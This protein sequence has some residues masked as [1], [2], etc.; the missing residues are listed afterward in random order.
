MSKQKKCEQ[1]GMVARKDGTPAM[2]H[3]DKCGRMLCW[4]CF[5]SC[6]LCKETP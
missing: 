6:K 1:C 4:R 5:H 3:K 2:I